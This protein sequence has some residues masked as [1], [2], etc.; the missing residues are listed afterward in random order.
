MTNAPVAYLNSNDGTALLAFG[1]GPTIAA[2]NNSMRQMVDFIE[3]HRGKYIF[4]YISYDLKNEIEELSS[5]NF[6]GHSFPNIYLWIPEHVVQIKDDHFEFLQGDPSIDANAFTKRFIEPVIPEEQP[7]AA[8]LIPRTTR[9]DYLQNVHHL[10]DHIQ[11][12]DLYEVN[13]CQEFYAEKVEISDPLSVYFRLNAITQAP[14]SAY[15]NLGD[16]QVFC[17]SPERFIKRTGNQLM[18]SP[19]KG[20][21]KRGVTPEEDVLYKEKLFKDPKER[22]ENVMIVD[23]VRNDL[24]KL[25][26]RNSVKVEELYGIHTYKTVHQMVS[27][28]SCTLKPDLNFEDI[29][30]AAFPMGS[31][32]GAP[33]ISAMEHIERYENFKRGLYSGSIGYI[34]P[35]GDFDFNVVIRTLLY[36]KRTKYLSCPVGGAI[37]INSSPEKE[38]EECHIKIA[39]ILEE[40][41]VTA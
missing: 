9:E 15:L 39:R 37:T 13:Y 12:G 10:K 30:R 31:M 40:L 19:I 32:T 11:N 6:D 5:D 17:G 28:I 29:L 18:S 33:K 41:N 35:N 1:E 14:F 38:Y 36:N 4:G 27:T 7:L 26:T 25:A 3:L 8:N 34:Q 21:H 22:S 2:F 23:L 20:T 24:S 16:H